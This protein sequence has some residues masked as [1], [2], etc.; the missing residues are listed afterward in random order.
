MRILLTNDDG[1][2]SEGLIAL[3]NIARSISNDIWICAPEMDQSCLSNS[4]TISKSLACRKI[5]N[6]RFAVRGTPV[7]CVIV[8]LQ[9]MGDKRPDLILSGVN[10]GTNT[11]NH[12]AYSGTLAAAFEGSLQGIRSF[13]LSQAY[14]NE[15]MIPWEVA[16]THAPNILHQLLKFNNI[17]N[18]TLFNINFPHCSPKDVEKIVI[19]KQEHPCFSLDAQQISENHNITNYSLE[20]RDHPRDLCEDSDAF[21]IKHNM[22]SVTPIKTDLTDYNSQQHMAIS[23]E[24]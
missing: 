5:S 24:K 15:N 6:Q 4:L 3:E 18:S 17:P 9:K 16:K 1:I 7:D 21:A 2:K 22:I 13:A 10:I 12:V 11:S 20:F 8:A 19:T 23:L 14:T